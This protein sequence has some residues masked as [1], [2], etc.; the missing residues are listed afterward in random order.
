MKTLPFTVQ[1]LLAITM[2]FIAP[3]AFTNCDKEKEDEEPAAESCIEDSS[4]SSG[5]ALSAEQCEDIVSGAQPA[6][7]SQTTGGTGSL[8]DAI[9][10]DTDGDDSD[11][12]GDTAGQRWSLHC[13]GN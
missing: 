13:H 3:F 1:N 9:L 11:D 2:I 7:E 5:A 6:G 4:S 10:D 12:G 8:P